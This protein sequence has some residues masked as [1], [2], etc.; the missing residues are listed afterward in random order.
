MD[1]VGQHLGQWD[2]G[3]GR[4][5]LGVKWSEC[6]PWKNEMLSGIVDRGESGIC[7]PGLGRTVGGGE[8]ERE[9]PPGEPISTVFCSVLFCLLSPSITRHLTVVSKATTKT[10]MFTTTRPIFPR[11][12]GSLVR[13][14]LHVQTENW[15]TPWLTATCCHGVMHPWHHCGVCSATPAEDRSQFLCSSC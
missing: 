7:D 15:P 14:S 6:I 10:R 11:C 5:V 2:E 9:E 12:P 1:R 8:R 3:Q 4:G 13:R